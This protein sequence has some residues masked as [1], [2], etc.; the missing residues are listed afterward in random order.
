MN[1]SF[2]IYRNEPLINVN[3]SN[4]AFS[5]FEENF[6]I[7]ATSQ[8]QSNIF[9]SLNYSNGIVSFKVNDYFVGSTQI[10]VE[11]VDNNNQIAKTPIN[12]TVLD[13]EVPR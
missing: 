3:V 7:I 6:N 2:T 10:F 11:I 13:C 5:D 9:T 1:Q 12:V 8:N 4:L